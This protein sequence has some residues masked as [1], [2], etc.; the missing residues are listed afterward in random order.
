[1]SEHTEQ[2]KLAAI[3]PL[4]A[5]LACSVFRRRRLH[6]KESP[7]HDDHQPAVIASLSR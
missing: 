1:M 6:V 2:R 7:N 4:P 5:K 3:I